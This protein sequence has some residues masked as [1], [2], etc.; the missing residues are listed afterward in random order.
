MTPM[1][2]YA[3]YRDRASNN[4][5][6]PFTRNL[7][8]NARASA[9]SGP[10]DYYAPY[11]QMPPTYSI[12]G[13]INQT[14]GATSLASTDSLEPLP[15]SPK[16]LNN[17]IAELKQKVQDEGTVRVIATL[18]EKFVPEGQLF[19]QSAIQAQQD[20][21]RAAQNRVLNHLSKDNYSKFYM[22]DTIPM[23]AT[24]VDSEGLNQLLAA[25]DIASIVEDGL[26]SPALAESSHV[27]GAHS[28]WATGFEGTDQTI[29][30]V[31]TG[32]DRTHSFFN[33]RVV[34]EACYSTTS[35]II[36]SMSTKACP[37]G[38]D[39]GGGA[40]EQTVSARQPHA[41]WMIVNTVHM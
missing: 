33:G 32:V 17:V 35:S 18:T 34:Q 12:S 24:E 30:I 9:H 27:I 1:A 2:N 38:T 25:N 20:N 4:W 3:A 22:F 26:L 5:F 31:D 28:A 16:V 13:T 40:W 41:Q 21:I 29:A 15:A 23:V 6:R 19:D 8:T 11:W 10:W 37:G 36:G 39:V 7:A 14:L